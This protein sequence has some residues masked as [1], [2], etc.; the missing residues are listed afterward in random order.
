LGTL[1]GVP[2]PQPTINV[3]KR[4]RQSDQ[5]NITDTPAP[6]PDGS[7]R[8]YRRRPPWIPLIVSVAVIVSSAYAVKP[9]RDVESLSEVSEAFLVRPVGYVAMAPVSNVLD[10]LTLL[11]IRQHIALFL[12]IVVLFAVGRLVRSRTRA[13]GWRGHL[14]AAALLLVSVV[15]SYATA[16]LLPRPMASLGSLDANVLRIDFHS[17]T[18]ASGDARQWF[19]VERN[20]AWHRD[21]GYDVAYVTDH[22]TVKGA[23]HGMADNPLAGM[24]G[25]VLLQAIE[26]TW[27]GEHV[28]ILGAERAYR[29]ILTTNLRDVDEQGLALASVVT[30]REP[31]VI[32]NHPRELNRLPPASGPMTGG[33]RAIEIS[34]GA[35]D[36]RDRI[37][38]QRAAILALAQRHNLALTTGSDNHGWGRTA[39]NWTLMRPTNWRGLNGDELSLRIERVIRDGG[40][41]GTRVIERVVADPDATRWS[42]PLSVFTIPGRMLTTL[43]NDERVMWLVWTW[44]IFAAVWGFRRARARA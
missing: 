29:G 22:A 7:A 12:G 8:W 25:V 21:G 39:P 44:G 5:R 36:G 15:A 33:V 1:S 27:T 32:W 14:G 24:D 10:M 17:H 26:V 6:G 28:A 31:V 19:T 2:R 11:S 34:N 41:R 23:E 18:S 20:R 3:P 13:A 40:Y 37:N 35:P 38:Q 9:V 42:L 16:V 30:G 4:I 43:S